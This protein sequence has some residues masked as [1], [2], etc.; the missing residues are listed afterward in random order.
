VESAPPAGFTGPGS[1]AERVAL[2]AA[3]HNLVTLP[4]TLDFLTAASLGC[5]FATAYRA[6]TAHGRVGPGDWVS[7]YGC[8]GLGLSA[9]MIALAL[10]ARVVAVDVSPA[11]LALAVDLGAEVAIDARVPDPAAAVREA[12]GG[13]TVVSMDA[14]G[15]SATAVASV[16]SLRRRGRHLQ[17][18][19]LLGADA[20]PPLP[21]DLVISRELE[22]YGSHGMAA[23]EYPGMLDLIRSGALHPEMLVGSVIGLEGVPA[24]LMAMDGPAATPGITVVNVTRP[25]LPA[26]PG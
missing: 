17:V 16:S 14:L 11:A 4:E 24:A 26:P 15:S 3:D 2:H 23:H 25:Q 10:G 1:F 6:L 9:V 22:L 21:M 13:G 20:A 5:R 8:G 7:V 18:G 12:S 19:L